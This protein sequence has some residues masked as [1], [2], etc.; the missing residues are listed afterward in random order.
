[1]HALRIFLLPAR[2]SQCQKKTAVVFLSVEIKYLLNGPAVHLMLGL[3]AEHLRDIIVV[4]R[5]C[6]QQAFLC[7]SREVAIGRYTIN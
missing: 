1:M 2:D 5:I 6:V 7:A 4:A 3:V